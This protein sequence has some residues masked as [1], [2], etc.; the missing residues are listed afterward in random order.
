MKL[1]NDSK[2]LI[3][4]TVTV[5]MEVILM[6][7]D[8]ERTPF[9][10]RVFEDSISIFKNEEFKEHGRALA[11]QTLN[12]A[13]AFVGTHSDC[14]GEVEV[15]VAFRKVELEEDDERK[16][17]TLDLRL[18]AAIHVYGKTLDQIREELFETTAGLL[19]RIPAEA[20]EGRAI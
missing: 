15:A 17:P 5:G 14:D 11:G 4:R 7:A 9:W 6:D 3:L 2:H 20:G 1:L 13:M 18:T 8:D 19:D 12:Q 10:K 16:V